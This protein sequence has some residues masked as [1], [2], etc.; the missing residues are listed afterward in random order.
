M[1]K[2]INKITV[3]RNDGSTLVLYYAK[4]Y[5]AWLKSERLRDLRDN[6]ELKEVT[7]SK[8]AYRGQKTED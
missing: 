5:N 7:E 6:G 3:V 8:V 1:S 2:L 4:P